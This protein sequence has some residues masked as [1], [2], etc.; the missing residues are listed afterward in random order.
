[1]GLCV[2]GTGTQFITS[3]TALAA[4]RAKQLA[5]QADIVAG[6]CSSVSWAKDAVASSGGAQWLTG[7]FAWVCAALM[8]DTNMGTPK[9]FDPLVNLAR[10]HAGQSA[11]RVRSQETG[12]DLQ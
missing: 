11:V 6:T 12:T 9:A 5:L 1:M 10:P 3:I 4:Y 8:L 7:G 2:C